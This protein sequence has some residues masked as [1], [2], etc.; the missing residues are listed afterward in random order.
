MH[1]NYEDKL[2]FCLGSDLKVLIAHYGV[3]FAGAGLA[4]AS[5]VI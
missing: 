5:V 2:I 1:A 3:S 4:V